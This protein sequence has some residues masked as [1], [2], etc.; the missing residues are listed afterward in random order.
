MKHFAIALIAA[1]AAAD[2]WLDYQVKYN[3]SLKPTYLHSKK[4]SDAD[5]DYRTLNIYGNNS[6]F[7]R[8]A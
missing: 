5:T 1:T 6:L 2:H 7:L 8:L 3:G 4:W